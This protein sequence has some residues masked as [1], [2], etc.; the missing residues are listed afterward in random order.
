MSTLW[1]NLAGAYLLCGL[2][3]YGF[4]SIARARWIASGKIEPLKG[5]HSELYTKIGI[6][7]GLLFWP[8]FLLGVPLFRRI[9]RRKTNK[10]VGLCEHATE[11]DPICGPC[12]REIE[13]DPA[14][15]ALRRRLTEIS[16]KAN[17]E[18][19]EARSYYRC[20]SCNLGFE[21][22]PPSSA[23][24]GMPLCTSCSKK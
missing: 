18:L 17:A 3:L 13:R 7:L 24:D 4:G 19:G 12:S 10:Y 11:L 8:L 6:A 21:G 15:E 22:F 23:T 9:N 5:K 1:V 16:A 2:V 20:S 14:E